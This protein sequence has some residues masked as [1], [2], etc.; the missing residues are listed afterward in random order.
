MEAELERL[1][2]LV[3]EANMIAAE[4]QRDIRFN[5]NLTSILPEFDT[6]EISQS[7]KRIF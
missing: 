1:F 4:F 6:D 3:R 7:S 5:S 2:P